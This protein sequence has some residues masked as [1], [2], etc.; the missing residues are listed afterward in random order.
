MAITPEGKVKKM[1]DKMLKGK[2]IWYFAP[3]SG[4]YGVSGIP[5]RIACVAGTFVGIECKRDDKAQLTALQAQCLEKIKVA[6]GKTAVV[7]DQATVISL[8]ISLQGL[9]DAKNEV[10][11][12]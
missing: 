7:Y 2:G 6:G 12:A 8:S 5:D 10:H 9:I 1:L 3:Q 4:P 11:D